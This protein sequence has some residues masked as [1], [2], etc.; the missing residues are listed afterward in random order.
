MA[1]MVANLALGKMA[2]MSESRPRYQRSTG[3]LLGA[4]IV[5]VLLVVGFAG[6]RAL[7]RDNGPTPVRAVDYTAQVRA[8]RADGKLTVFAPDRLPLGWKATS[9]TYETGSAP[10]WHLGTLTDGGAYVGLE[11]SR[12]SVDDLVTEHV[13][14]NAERGKDLE[15]AGATWQTWT[16]AGGD[17]ALARTLDGPQGRETLLVVGSGKQR[18][19][20]Q[21][22]GDLRG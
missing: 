21:L 12:R 13:D 5:T 2:R 20:Q 4:M 3:G 15:L 22:A 10:S 11:E 6:F 8:G 9:A 19:V 7:T 17:Y 1:V 14:E 18:D 16:D